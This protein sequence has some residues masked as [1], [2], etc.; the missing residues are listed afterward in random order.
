MT[1]AT[2]PDTDDDAVTDQDDST[3]RPS[4]A[5]L[6]PA[7]LALTAAALLAGL[8]LG[9]GMADGPERVTDP[10]S[11]GFVRDMGVHHAQ[12][13]RMAEIAHRRSADPDLNPL[14][15]D[16]LSTQQ[17][18]IGIM[19]GWLDLW[20]QS[21]SASTAPMA[22]MDHDGPMPGLASAAELER[23]DALP[24]AEMEEL[25]LRLMIRHH[26]GAV[27]MADAA[28]EQADSPEV[29]AFAA[30]MSAGQQSEVDLM[31]R[32]LA[33]RGAPP[34]PDGAPTPEPSHDGH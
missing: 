8:L 24:V 17:G 10:V 15:F 20:E 14:A 31:Q 12:A 3:A 29:A 26:R 1:A 5:L 18:Q 28:A 16:I 11:L 23:L 9:R 13:V 19:S 4:R 27:P 25:W 21:Q 7:G 6:V 2:R 34:E 30:Q 22:W 33:E 32:L